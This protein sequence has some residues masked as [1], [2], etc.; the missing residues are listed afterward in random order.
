MLSLRNAARS[1]ANL[2]SGGSGHSARGA[3]PTS[4][5]TAGSR[6]S[7]P[8]RCARMRR[9][10]SDATR[11]ARGC[12]RSSGLF[13]SPAHFAALS[14]CRR[15]AGTPVQ[16][17]PQTVPRPACRAS[18]PTVR[19]DISVR[20]VFDYHELTMDKSVGAG[21][22]SVRPP[23][24]TAASVSRLS[25][26]I[27]LSMVAWSPCTKSFT[28]QPNPETCKGCRQSREEQFTSILS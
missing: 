16:S 12:H 26:L 11:A 3:A 28:G 19:D 13:P 23:A 27:A 9:R 22:G 6:A 2:P 21:G 5:S 18:L 15:H 7:M 24:S 14:V 10:T 4:T 1:A 8:Y 25:A 17:R 20:L